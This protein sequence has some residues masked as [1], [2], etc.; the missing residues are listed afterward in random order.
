LATGTGNFVFQTGE[1]VRD[2]LGE[3]YMRVHWEESET[4]RELYNMRTAIDSQ[5][6]KFEK[7][8]IER[9]EKLLKAGD[10]AKWGSGP[11]S[12]FKDEKQIAELRDKLLSD[13]SQAFT[14]MLPKE[15]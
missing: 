8:L 9:K 2:F 12:C 11:F 1:L 7:A 10:L 15:S 5:Y 3:D 13:K 14:Y 4:F 6:I